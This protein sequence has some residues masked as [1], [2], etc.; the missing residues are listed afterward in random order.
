MEQSS[1][2]HVDRLKHIEETQGSALPNVNFEY[3][4]RDRDSN[5]LAHI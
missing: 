4:G 3:T 1:S 5:A 2:F